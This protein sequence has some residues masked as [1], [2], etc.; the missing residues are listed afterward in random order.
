VDIHIL[1]E[2]TDTQYLFYVIYFNIPYHKGS[3]RGATFATFLGAVVEYAFMY[4]VY[5][6]YNMFRSYK[7]FVRQIT[8]VVAAL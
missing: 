1:R 8:Y 2:Q 3:L 6:F 4:Y 7:A 5:F